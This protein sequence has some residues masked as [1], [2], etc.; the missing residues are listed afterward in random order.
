MD[1]NKVSNLEQVRVSRGMT[2]A[3]LAEKSGVTL[4]TIY[5]FERFY[6]NIGTTEIDS[7]LN[8]C[9]ALNCRL[10]DILEGGDLIEKAKIVRA[11]APQRPF[12]NPS[13][14]VYPQNLLRD[15]FDDIDAV[16]ACVDPEKTLEYLYRLL[17]EKWGD[18]LKLRYR[19]KYKYHQI[20][21]MYQIS[22]ARSGQLVHSAIERLKTQD[23]ITCLL[24]GVDAY[25]VHC[26][27]LEREK[28][29]RELATLS[30]KQKERR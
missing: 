22:R 13:F 5:G 1:A 23:Y 8:L 18:I 30:D 14:F 26:E 29:Q 6:K 19:D 12:P 2:R 7:A 27:Q 9:I 17:P 20:G 21:D 15:V 28:E 16:Q 24:L 4:R 10:E 25:K 3:M 11:I